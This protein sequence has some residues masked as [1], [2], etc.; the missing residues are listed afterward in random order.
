MFPKQV[1]QA[2]VVRYC[3][4]TNLYVPCVMIRSE[5]S[6][7][8]RCAAQCHLEPFVHAYICS[9]LAVLQWFEI[10]QFMCTGAILASSTAMR[11][12]PGCTDS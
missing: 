12:P 7:V 3:L 6:I 11:L 5:L 2:F 8:W 9:R 10:V 1:K 4:H